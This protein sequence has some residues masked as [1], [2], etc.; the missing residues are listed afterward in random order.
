MP[1]ALTRMTRSKSGSYSVRK[2]IPTDVRDEY[3]TLYG[4]RWEAKLFLPASTPPQEAK[5][6]QAAF[7]AT[8]ETRLRTIREKRA[9]RTRS[10][11]EREA[12]ALA[13]EWYR[14]FVAQHE[15]NPG[16]VERWDQLY[17][18][19]ID[20]L[21]DHHPEGAAGTTGANLEWVRDPSVREGIRPA[22]AKE[23]RADQFLADRGLA[24]T[25]P[26]YAL[27]MDRV[28]E[29]FINAVQLMEKRAGG[30]YS[31]DQRLEQFPKFTEA[32]KLHKVTGL[33]PW[34]LFEAYVADVKPKPATVNRQRCVFLHLQK[35]FDGREL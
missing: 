2:V 3:E 6:K 4:Q 8:V 5:A 9:G 14:S 33:S 18:A 15:D 21:E 32:P 22:L 20:R 24:L 7:L 19:L 13:G 23:T 1:F 28:L 31:P 25:P 35:Q 12:L 27:F 16:A 34:A 26:A 11:N 10:L 30:D 29:E 17:W